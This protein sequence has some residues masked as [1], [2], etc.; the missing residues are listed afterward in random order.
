MAD[1]NLPRKLLA[2]LR[3]MPNA[4]PAAEWVAFRRR[5]VELRLAT[6]GPMRPSWLETEQ[7]P[8]ISWS[9][10]YAALL[11][12]VFSGAVIVL[13]WMMGHI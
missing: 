3:R 10:R 13:L 6:G 11:V 2:E 5:P 4:T 8:T 9:E 12:C 7:A 1:L